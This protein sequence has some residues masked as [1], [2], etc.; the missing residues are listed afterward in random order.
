V[1]P[2]LRCVQ[3]ACSPYSLACSPI[4]WPAP[5]AT[6]LASQCTGSNKQLSSQG[7]GSNDGGASC[8]A[9]NTVPTCLFCFALCLLQTR[10]GR[11]N[12]RAG[13][14]TPPVVHHFRRVTGP[15]RAPS[16]K[17]HP[18]RLSGLYKG[19]F[20]PHGCEILSVS[21]D[22]SGPAAQIVATKITGG[23]GEPQS[24]CWG[25][26]WLFSVH[27]VF[28]TRTGHTYDVY[29]AGKGL[30]HG[31]YHCLYRAL[32]WAGVLAP[33]VKVT[34]GCRTYALGFIEFRTCAASWH[35][36]LACLSADS[37]LPHTLLCC[38]CCCHRFRCRGSNVPAGDVTWRAAATPLPTP[39]ALPH[40]SS[41]CLSTD[42]FLVRPICCAALPLLPLQVTPMFLQ[43]RSH[44]AQLQ[45]PCPPPGPRKRRRW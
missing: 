35:R 40:R 31:Q 14:E 38:C 7:T 15:L 3:S 45:L 1:Q 43:A 5:P 29:M 37:L 34:A 8:A 9:S 27:A 13:S 4:P 26:S 36:A 33:L 41:A 44:G 10:S 17:S 42:V 30:W 22:F 11:R 18:H 19:L 21:Y 28:S 25:R 12:R 16:S 32:G 24:C 23:A 39:L 2:L 20:G 6:L